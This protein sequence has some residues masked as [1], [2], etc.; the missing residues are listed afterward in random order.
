M[1]IY[2]I[3]NIFKPN[4]IQFIVLYEHLIQSSRVGDFCEVWRFISHHLVFPP[5]FL[6]SNYYLM[7][8]LFKFQSALY[9]QVIC[10]LIDM[11]AGRPFVIIIFDNTPVMCFVVVIGF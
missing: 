4:F 2:E 7:D 5:L 10:H 11:L 3:K 8:V 1:K 9:L 6:T